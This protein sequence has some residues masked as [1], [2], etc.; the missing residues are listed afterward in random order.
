MI[1]GPRLL[2]DFDKKLAQRR[3]ADYFRNLKIFEALYEEAKRLCVLPTKDPL[4]GVEVDIY[5]A[6]V[7][8][9]RT[10]SGKDRTRA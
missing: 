7:L 6:K 3:K 8:N 9:V 10:S 4:E 2:K 1:K 5:L